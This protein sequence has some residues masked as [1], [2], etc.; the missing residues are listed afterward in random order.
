MLAA[1]DFLAFSTPRRLVR[2]LQENFA[3]PQPVSSSAIYADNN[4]ATP[5]EEDDSGDRLGTDMD[6][7]TPTSTS[8]GWSV[9]TNPIA[10]DE[11]LK[12]ESDDS[13]HEQGR[14]AWKKMVIQPSTSPTA[15]AP[16][17]PPVQ[18]TDNPDINDEFRLRL[19]DPSSAATPL[20]QAN[21]CSQPELALKNGGNPF[22]TESG[23]IAEELKHEVSEEVETKRMSLDG[24]AA[25]NLQAGSITC[26]SVDKWPCS[27][28]ESVRS[29]PE[30]GATTASDLTAESSEEE[31]DM[32]TPAS[33][34]IV[35]VVK[36]DSTMLGEMTWR[37]FLRREWRQRLK[38]AFFS[39]QWCAVFVAIPFAFALS[40]VVCPSD[41]HLTGY[42][43]P[44]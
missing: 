38:S 13:D 25:T 28:D 21:E 27:E 11:S 9:R 5:P 34:A 42:L 24:E 33:I 6:L 2:S 44:T 29:E 14:A 30:N 32:A 19:D 12:T 23:E 22:R 36:N 15:P 37:K 10:S 20:T 16:H 35:P 31:K 39:W 1:E 7:G 17:T 43:V 3:S 26:N 18:E 41:P 4:S 40:K 8:T